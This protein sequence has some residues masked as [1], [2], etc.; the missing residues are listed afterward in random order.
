VPRRFLS[1]QRR[2]LQVAI[3]LLVDEIREGYY[4]I[5]EAL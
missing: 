3:S 1:E 4:R 2:A 5:R